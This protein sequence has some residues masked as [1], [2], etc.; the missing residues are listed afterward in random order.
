M[1]QKYFEFFHYPPCESDF[2]NF[3]N[4]QSFI[5]SCNVQ[6]QLHSLKLIFYEENNFQGTVCFFFHV[7][8]YK[9]KWADFAEMSLKIQLSP[10][11]YLI[12]PWH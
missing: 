2:V 3:I 9:H 4:Q 11:F 8:N 7:I 5:T 1:V 6:L 10:R 12:V